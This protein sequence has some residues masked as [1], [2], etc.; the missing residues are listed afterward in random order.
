MEVVTIARLKNNLTQ[1]LRRVAA[2]ARI[3]IRNRNSPVAVL[4]PIEPQPTKNR[5]KLG[6]GRASGKIL[7]DP[8][9]PFMPS[10][11]W[12]MLR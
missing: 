5:T 10:S 4:I 12:E 2:G 6:C 8:T 11:D 1:F 9:E 7:S 3:E